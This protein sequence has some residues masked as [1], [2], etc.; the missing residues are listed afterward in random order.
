M[1]PSVCHLR[2]T[3]TLG[4]LGGLGLG[5]FGPK[6]ALWY[7]GIFLRLVLITGILRRYFT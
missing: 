5:T 6:S 3:T 2:D 1:P 4:L 7:L